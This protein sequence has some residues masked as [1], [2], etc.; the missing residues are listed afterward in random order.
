MALWAASRAQF[1]MMRLTNY[2]YSEGRKMGKGFWRDR[3]RAVVTI[4]F[5]LFALTFA[6]VIIVYGEMILKIVISW[7]AFNREI[8]YELNRM[9][10]I[11]RWPLTV[12]LYLFMVSYNYYILPMDR[13]KFRDILPGAVFASVGMFLATTIFRLYANNTAN[14]D[15]IYGALATVV[16]IMIWFYILAWFLGV[17]VMFNKAWDDTKHMANKRR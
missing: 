4:A 1:A 15:I 16:V 3:M 6:L 5:T 10:F 8:A 12:F 7:F 13:K 2:T 9:W 17:G 14:Y 11:V